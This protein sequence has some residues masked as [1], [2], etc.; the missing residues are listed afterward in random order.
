MKLRIKQIGTKIKEIFHKPYIASR[1]DVPF[2]PCA[3][4]SKT[5]RAGGMHHVIEVLNEWR[6]LGD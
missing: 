3:S 6:T 4:R 2:T 5:F 1:N